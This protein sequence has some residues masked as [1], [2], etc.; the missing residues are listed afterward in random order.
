MLNCSE[1]QLYC[2]QGRIQPVR[3]AI[4]VIFVVKSQRLRYCRK[5]EVYFTTVLW[6]NNGWQNGLISRML[7]SEL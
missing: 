4:S 2:T 1:R 6:Q 5:D 3:G 7:F